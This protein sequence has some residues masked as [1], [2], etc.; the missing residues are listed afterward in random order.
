MNN[1]SLIGPSQILY[2]TN[3]YELQLL[4]NS[5][6]NLQHKSLVENKSLAFKVILWTL[7]TFRPQSVV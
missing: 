5:Y 7:A 4:D 2:Y 3:A 6:E 1:A